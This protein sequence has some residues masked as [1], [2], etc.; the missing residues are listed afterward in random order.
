MNIYSYYGAFS[1][2]NTYSFWSSV[3]NDFPLRYEMMGYDSLLGSHFDKYYVDYDSY[4]VNP[5]FT[6]ED[7]AP[8]AS[9]YAR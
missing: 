7:F 4:V 2:V 8:P 1:Q 3:E 9:K 5:V 6:D